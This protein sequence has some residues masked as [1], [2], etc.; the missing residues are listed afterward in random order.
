MAGWTIGINKTFV[1]W[2]LGLI[3]VMNITCN[4]VSPNEGSMVMFKVSVA[5]QPEELIT[6]R[7][8]PWVT[9]PGTTEL[10]KNWVL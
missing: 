10:A 1:Y 3:G 4:A 8:K 5:T 6:L 7:T 9:N 2:V